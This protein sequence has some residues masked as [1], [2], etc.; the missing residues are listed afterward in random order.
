MKDLHAE[1]IFTWLFVNG[2]IQDVWIPVL[3]CKLWDIFRIF[4]GITVNFC[5]TSNFI[6]GFFLC[7]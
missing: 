2:Y 5:H 4:L 6:F 1:W 7:G 3:C